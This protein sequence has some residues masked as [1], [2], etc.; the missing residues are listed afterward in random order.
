M[1]ACVKHT[2]SQHSFGVLSQQN[3]HDIKNYGVIF[4]SKIDNIES[5]SMF[6]SSNLNQYKLIMPNL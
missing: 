2:H 3:L 4:F 5:T 1:G 6:L